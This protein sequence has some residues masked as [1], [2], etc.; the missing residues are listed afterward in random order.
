MEPVDI[1]LL[2]IIA[3]P[4]LVG[5]FYGFLNILF[6][7][8]AW[9]VACGVAVK[10]SSVFEPM[11]VEFID[12]EAIR[13]GLAFVGLFLVSLMVFSTLGYLIVKLLGR[14][15][16][17]AADRIL[18]L[19]FG[20]GLGGA[21]V[22]LVIFFAGFTAFPQEPWW[23]TSKMIKPFQTICVLGRQYL[24]QSVAEH[25][26]YEANIIPSIGKIKG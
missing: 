21:I 23:Q 12:S 18:G 25:H 24:P 8:L 4:A 5:V 7:L 22:T 11:L 10:F 13:M 20:V 2:V 17:T 9:A 19:L 6:S 26:S 3:I 16:L 1:V 15:G 14:S